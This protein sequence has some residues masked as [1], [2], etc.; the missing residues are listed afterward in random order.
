[1]KIILEWKEKSSY[2]FQH[3]PFHLS[4]EWELFANS[5]RVLEQSHGSAGVG[6]STG[7]QPLICLTSS[8]WSPPQPVQPHSHTLS[9]LGFG[10]P[11]LGS[12]AGSQLGFSARWKEQV[13]Q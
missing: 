12:H 4:L 11:S 5:P 9:G 10:G 2:H 6:V 13:E 7:G 8:T 3:K 1:M